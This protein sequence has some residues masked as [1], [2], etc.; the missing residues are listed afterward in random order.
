MAGENNN[1][2]FQMWKLIVITITVESITAAMVCDER[3]TQIFKIPGPIKCSDGSQT[4]FNATLWKT[5]IRGVQDQC[6]ITED[7]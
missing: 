1:A 6:D 3:G 2:L 5:N 4:V 7:Y